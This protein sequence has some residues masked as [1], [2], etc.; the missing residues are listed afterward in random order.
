M[1]ACD[2]RIF[3]RSGRSVR[4]ND[5]KPGQR[6]TGRLQRHRVRLRGDGQWEN[7]HDGGTRRRNGHHGPGHQ[8]FVRHRQQKCLPIHGEWNERTPT[9]H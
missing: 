9:Q 2:G 3:S 7:P 5:E 6:H 4:E 1:N 8:R